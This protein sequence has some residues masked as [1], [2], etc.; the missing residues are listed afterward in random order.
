[1]VLYF[2]IHKKWVLIHPN[3]ARSQIWVAAHTNSS[4][5]K[6]FPFGEDLIDWVSFTEAEEVS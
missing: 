1:M 5:T 6:C 4:V 2:Y 3:N